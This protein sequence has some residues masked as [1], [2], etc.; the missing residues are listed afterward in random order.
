MTES[1]LVA[2]WLAENDLVPRAGHQFRLRAVGLAGLDGVIN[3]DVIEVVDRRRIDMIWRTEEMHLGVTWQLRVAP[4]GTTVEVIQTG[5]LGVHG[6]SRRDALSRAYEEAFGSRLRTVLDG[7]AAELERASQAKSKNVRREHP[8]AIPAYAADAG[9]VDPWAAAETVHLA[10]PMIFESPDPGGNE[11]AIGGPRDPS[12]RE[13]EWEAAAP[14]PTGSGQRSCVGVALLAVALTGCAVVLTVWFGTPGSPSPPAGG[15]ADGPLMGSAAGPGDSA[16]P[17]PLGTAAGNPGGGPGRTAGPG[18]TP[19]PSVAVDVTG[20]DGLE[21]AAPSVP[22]APVGEGDPTPEPM[23]AALTAAVA[24]GDDSG[25]YVV[26]VANPGA[27][28]VTNWTVVLTITGKPPTEVDGATMSRHGNRLSF[29]PTGDGSVVPAY[30]SVSFVLGVAGS[31]QECT[32]DG[33]PCS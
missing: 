29:T 11:W 2:S 16:R 24:A 13:Y 9:P 21:T 14:A 19:A 5:Y 30:G 1:R 12:F 20:Q 23:A 25:E 32:I 17:S 10:E 15:L 31:I 6:N 8:E 3:A 33:R 7:L 26:T 4:D 27:V 18:A 22:V 28:P